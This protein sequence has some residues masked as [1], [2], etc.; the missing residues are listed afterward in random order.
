MSDDRRLPHDFATVYGSAGQRPRMVGLFRLIWPLFP[1]CFVAGW[2][3]HAAVPYPRLS[4]SLAGFLFVLLSAGLALCSTWGVRR[5]HSFLKGAQGEDQ[6]ARILSLLSSDFTIFNDLELPHSG[7]SIDHIVLSPNALFVVET[8]NWRGT[9]TVENGRV[10]CNGEEP[11]RP[12]L[13]Q[14][15]QLAA[16]LDTYLNGKGIPDVLVIPVLCFVGNALEKDLSNIGGV[17]VCNE[18]NLLAVFDST[19]E[20]PLPRGTQKMV[21]SEL[22]RCVDVVD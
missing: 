16:E 6:V 17:R 15:K 8:K 4:T 10:L 9:L 7:A 5:L 2:L 1:F 21:L 18:K 22:I 14:A 20:P 19:M 11:D 12:P 3:L 13:K